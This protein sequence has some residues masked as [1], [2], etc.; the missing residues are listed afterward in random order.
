MKKVIK[1]SLIGLLCLIL[2]AAAVLGCMLFWHYP[3][4]AANRRSLSIPAGDGLEN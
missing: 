2:A 4:F 3:R 1:A